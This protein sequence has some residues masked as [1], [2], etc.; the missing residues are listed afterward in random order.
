MSYDQCLL[1]GSPSV[2]AP[3]QYVC[4]QCNTYLCD[5]CTRT[6][7]T[8]TCIKR[9]QGAHPSVQHNL[10]VAPQQNGYISQQGC[11]TQ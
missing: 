7:P 3:K 8:N 5:L 1:H 11:K 6:W 10:T 2:Y 4:S 9:P